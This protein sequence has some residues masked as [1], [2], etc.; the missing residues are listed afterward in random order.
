MKLLSQLRIMSCTFPDEA[1][2]YACLF[3]TRNLVDLVVICKRRLKS[4][5]LIEHAIQ[6][7]PMLRSCTLSPCIETFGVSRL[8]QARHI[9][10]SSASTT[11]T[12]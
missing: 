12:W 9:L 10:Q 5:T 2:L 3:G 6:A 7:Q 1:A 11:T 4:C 8:R